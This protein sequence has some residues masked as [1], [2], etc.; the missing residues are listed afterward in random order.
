MCMDPNPEH[1]SDL[2][3]EP[4]LTIICH[5]TLSFVLAATPDH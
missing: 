3:P 2:D 1:N 4:T 5:L